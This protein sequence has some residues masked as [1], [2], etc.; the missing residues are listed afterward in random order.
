MW[1][2]AELRWNPMIK[3][4]VIIAPKRQSRPDENQDSKKAI[5][6]ITNNL[7]PF[8]LG[9]NK[10]LPAY[11]DVWQHDNDFPA[12][13]LQNDE[14]TINK[15]IMTEKGDDL[16]K[17]VPSYGKCEVIL[18]SPDHQSSLSLLPAEH[19]VKLVELWSDRYKVLSADIK[20]KY[21]FIF[22]NRGD[23]VGVTISHPHGQIYAYSKIPKKIEIELDSCKEFYND[24]KKCLFC[25]MNEEEKAFKR[26]V[27]YENNHFIAYV[28]FFADYAFGVY[29]T[30]T[31]HK[32]NITD[33]KTE[34]EKQSLADII[35]MITGAYDKLYDMPFPYMM[36]MHNTPCNVDEK[37]IGYENFYHFHIEFYP[38]LRNKN[39]QQYQ[40]SSETGVW[41]HGNPT[42]PEDKAVDLRIALL[43]FRES[44]K[45]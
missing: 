33:F 6:N 2:L 18:Y 42:N 3:D 45:Q 7:C 13:S 29:I 28:P 5:E 15:N 22:E 39:Q 8:C 36:C 34:E 12:L 14:T 35:K 16:Y 20:I 25:R 21:V 38:P 41:T 1:K 30:S 31:E 4:W 23:K 10:K 19:L 44:L 40:A 27:I 9:N 32:S 11:Y 37:N 17:V 26:R 24:Q 43:K